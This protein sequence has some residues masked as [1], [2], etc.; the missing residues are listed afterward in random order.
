MAMKKVG[1]DKLRRKVV[2]FLLVTLMMATITPVHADEVSE[3]TTAA[4]EVTTTETKPT[5][6][7]KK[8]TTHHK[9]K[10]VKK[11]KKTKKKN[12]KKDGKKKSKQKEKSK[13]KENKKST[14]PM[15]KRAVKKKGCDT[16]Q[17]KIVKMQSKIK[18]L[19]KEQKNIR[20]EIKK[21]NNKKE[22]V[23]ELNNVWFRYDKTSPDILRGLN[24]EVYKNEVLCILGGNG[25]GKSTT[26]GVI[27]G[28]NR[29]YRGNV[30]INKKKIEKYKLSELFNNN[31]AV[32]P[33]DPQSLFVKSVLQ[34]DLEEVLDGT[35][36]SKSEKTERVKNISELLGIVNLLKMHPYD[37][38]GG[39]QQRIA[40]ART[41]LKPCEIILADEPT[42]NLDSKAYE[43]DRWK[44]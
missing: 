6:I 11:D 3:P 16:V 15:P 32:L 30:Y 44:F 42:G 24:L 23:I 1:D 43:R 12:T 27:S 18:K 31:L 13:K 20:K 38:S 41:M 9:K 7:E 34:D 37:L 33:Q 22:S 4:T 40:I 28:S 29:A 39:E 25:T 35:K 36:L 8:E 21:E 2:S 14:I 19:Q 5:T 17:K 10:T 26:L